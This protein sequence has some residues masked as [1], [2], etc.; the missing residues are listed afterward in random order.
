MLRLN[1]ER[2]TILRL[3]LEYA[4][5]SA[6]VKGTALSAKSHL[7]PAMRMGVSGFKNLLSSEIHDLTFSNVCISVVSYTIIAP[8]DGYYYHGFV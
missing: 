6:S 3:I 7:L 5:S 2:I 8:T 1:T 4:Y